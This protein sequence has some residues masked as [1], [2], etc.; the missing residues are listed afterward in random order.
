VKPCYFYYIIKCFNSNA[1]LNK[2]LNI[3]FLIVLNIIYV[4]IYIKNKKLMDLK[5]SEINFVFE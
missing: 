3:A 4:I 1:Y 5:Y 2:I